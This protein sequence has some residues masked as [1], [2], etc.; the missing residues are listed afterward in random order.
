MKKQKNPAIV[1]ACVTVLTVSFTAL[2]QQP[3]R[4]ADRILFSGLVRSD[5]GVLGHVAL[6]PMVGGAVRSDNGV[7]GTIFMKPHVRGYAVKSDLG[8][9]GWVTFDVPPTDD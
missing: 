6:A 3:A 7:L 2:A 1:V 4:K 9:P 8:T 5:R